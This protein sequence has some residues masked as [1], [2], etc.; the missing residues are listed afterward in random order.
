MEVYDE[1]IIKFK[2]LCHQLERCPINKENIEG[3]LLKLHAF[4]KDLDMIQFF[5][6][7]LSATAANTITTGK[8]AN[9]TFH[10]T[11]KNKGN[12]TGKLIEATATAA[13]TS[14]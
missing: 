2:E 9:N 6:R 8:T 1:I 7:D 13:S 11:P 10:T 14:L 4:S 5:I 3:C 12:T